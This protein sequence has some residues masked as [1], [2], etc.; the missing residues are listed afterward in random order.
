MALQQEKEFNMRE[1]SQNSPLPNFPVK[2]IHSERDARRF[3]KHLLVKER[4]NFHPDNNFADYVEDSGETTY[5]REER[6]LRQSLMGQC[7]TLL[8]DRIYEVA[9]EQMQRVIGRV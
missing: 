7:R 9:L 6:R 2:A 3:F 4:L 8:G 5:T 1:N